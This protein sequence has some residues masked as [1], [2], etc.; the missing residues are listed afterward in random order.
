MIFEGKP[1]ASFSR[2]ETKLKIN[3][4][5]KDAMNLSV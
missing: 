5:K 2:C 3:S 4:R 1:A